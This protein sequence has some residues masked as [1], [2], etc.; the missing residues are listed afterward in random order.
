MGNTGPNHLKLDKYIN[1]LLMLN[2]KKSCGKYSTL[3]LTYETNDNWIF[4]AKSIRS[5]SNWL[6]KKLKKKT[7]YN[8]KHFLMELKIQVHQSDRKHV[9]CNI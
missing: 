2:V 7:I 5:K 9:D 3:L 6:D 1:T 4:Y 8:G